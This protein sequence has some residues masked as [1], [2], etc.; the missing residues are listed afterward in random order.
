M[1]ILKTYWHN[2]K[3]SYFRLWLLSIVSIVAGG[4]LM[5]NP[6]DTSHLVIRFVGF[7]WTLEGIVFALEIFHKS[8]TETLS[9]K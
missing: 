9:N 1:E 2:F 4:S 3:N 5:F 7:V 8:I 6:E